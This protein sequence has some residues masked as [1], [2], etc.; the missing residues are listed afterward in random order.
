[1]FFRCTVFLVAFCLHACFTLVSQADDQ[2][3]DLLIREHW[4]WTLSQS[5]VFAGQ[6]GDRS[7]DG[8]LPDVSI[9]K[10]GWSKCRILKTVYDDV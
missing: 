2:D 8:K 6:L 7:G 3:V 1:M 4:D 5:P 10:N 9:K